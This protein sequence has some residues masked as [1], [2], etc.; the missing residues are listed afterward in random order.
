LEEQDAPRPVQLACWAVPCLV[1]VIISH[2]YALL[3]VQSIRD[4]ILRFLT[5]GS[6]INA[7]GILKT[8][9]TNGYKSFD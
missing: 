8:F 1:T 7:E 4:V 3:E 6:Y 9:H 5:L 2:V